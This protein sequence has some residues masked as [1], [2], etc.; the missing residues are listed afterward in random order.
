M[1]TIIALDPAT[2]T[3]WALR[4][5]KGTITSGSIKLT[6]HAA[7]LYGVTQKQAHNRKLE[8]DALC[9]FVETFITSKQCFIVSE[10]PG[11]YR[12]RSAVLSAWHL[13]RAIH[14][15]INKSVPKGVNLEDSVWFISPTAMKKQFTGNGRAKKPD[16]ILECKKRGFKTTENNEADAIAILLC[17]LDEHPE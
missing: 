8:A 14:E 16:I 5:N 4:D 12:S 2:T 13:N 1:K 9:S 10:A 15:A 6:K 17:Y 3:G 7:Q 11:R